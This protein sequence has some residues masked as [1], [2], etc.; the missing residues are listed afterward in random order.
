MTSRWPLR[1]IVFWAVIVGIAAWILANPAH[2]GNQVAEF[3]TTLLGL[4]QRAADALMTFFQ[5][6]TT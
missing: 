2:A 6:L 1:R 3:A 4:C 5:D